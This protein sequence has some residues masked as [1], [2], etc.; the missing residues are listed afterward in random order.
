[1]KENLFLHIPKTAGS[2]IRHSLGCR[3]NGDSVY[4]G[5]EPLFFLEKNLPL[6]FDR[7]NK[8]IFTVVRNPYTRAFSYYKHF[9]RMHRIKI[10]FSE[11]LY[12]IKVKASFLFTDSKLDFND[13]S[14]FFTFNQTFYLLNSK[15]IIDVDKV[16]RFE[17]LQE[18]ES[19]FNITLSKI[20]DGRYDTDEYM[21]CYKDIS[22][23]NIVKHIYYEDFINF[24]YSLKFDHSITL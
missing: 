4:R 17:N 8:F 13:K 20:N 5:H 11:F 3:N 24:N 10:P 21:N 15:N 23:V 16:Y 6:E 12:L 1:M 2:S 22:N 9:C 18:L 7:N 14:P 19:D